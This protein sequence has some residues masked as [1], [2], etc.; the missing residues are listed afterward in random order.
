MSSAETYAYTVMTAIG[1]LL[2]LLPL[3]W[4]WQARN[5]GTL[6][7]I[8]WAFVGNLN[9]FVNSIIWRGNMGNPAPVWCDISSKIAIGLG[10]AYPACSLCINRRLFNIA[11]SRHVSSPAEVCCY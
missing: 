3:P 4:H 2:V 6:L 10:V 9:Y 11:T 7:Y 5:S 8:F 1:M